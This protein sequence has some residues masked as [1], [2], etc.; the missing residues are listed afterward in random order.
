MDLRKV[1]IYLE[2]GLASLVVAFLLTRLLS[3]VL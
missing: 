3:A 1:I 2:M